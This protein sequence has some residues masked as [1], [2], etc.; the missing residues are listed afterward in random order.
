MKTKAMSMHRIHHSQP[1]YPILE[2]ILAFIW[3]A[4]TLAASCSL[5]LDSGDYKRLPVAN[6]FIVM[7]GALYFCDFCYSYKKLDS[8]VNLKQNKDTNQKR[9]N[10]TTQKNSEENKT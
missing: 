6:I 2:M 7:L 3:S 10:S 1:P 4:F 9:E 8:E 5:A